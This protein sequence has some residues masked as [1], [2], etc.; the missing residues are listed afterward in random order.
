MLERSF[1][2]PEIRPNRS[3]RAATAAAAVMLALLATVSIWGATRAADGT[4]PAAGCAVASTTKG[5][6]AGTP[7]ADA[8]CVEIDMHDIYFGA[9]LVTI[10]AD[11]DV[12]IVLENAGAAQH[13]FVINDHENKDVKN[14]E[15]NVAVDPGKTGETTINAPA[16]TYYFWCDI[17]GHEAAGMWGILKV[18]ENGPI[19]AQSVDN[20]KDA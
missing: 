1:S 2:M 5:A 3:L 6:P 16:G 9:N 14:L 17:P 8:K 7:V 12:K 4:P 19:T 18:E 20:P 13:T 15:I 10:P 11:T